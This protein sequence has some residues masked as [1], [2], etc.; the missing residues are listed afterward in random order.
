[1]E[2]GTR[3]FISLADRNRF[4]RPFDL[5]VLEA[6]QGAPFNVLHVCRDNNHQLD[7][8]DYPAAFHGRRQ[9]NPASPGDEADPPLSRARHSRRR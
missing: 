8:L 7:V 4:A 6:V 9:R 2:W 5:R 3:D 1:V